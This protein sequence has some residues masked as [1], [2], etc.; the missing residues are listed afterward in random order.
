MRRWIVM[1]DLWQKEFD[2]VGPEIFA[3]RLNRFHPD[4]LQNQN[5]KPDEREAKFKSF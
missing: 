4:F 2:Q 5:W 1:L 3:L